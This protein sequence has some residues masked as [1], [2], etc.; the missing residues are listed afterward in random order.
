VKV[1]L[2]VLYFELFVNVFVLKRENKR[3]KEKML[4][5]NNSLSF[6]Q[7]LSY[8]NGSNKDHLKI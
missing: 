2:T 5:N 6:V 8:C 7:F 4:S 3:K 1:V